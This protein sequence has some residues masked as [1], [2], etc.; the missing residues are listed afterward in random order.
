MVTFDVWLPLESGR[1]PSTSLTSAHDPNLRTSPR[2]EKSS[3]SPSQYLIWVLVYARP[4]T[5]NYPP[6]LNFTPRK[7]ATTP[8]VYDHKVVAI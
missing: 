8:T 7:N 1:C 5:E 6:Y 3:N 4:T 2:N